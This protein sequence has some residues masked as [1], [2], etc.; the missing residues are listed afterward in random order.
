[1]GFN[2][3]QCGA[4]Y[5]VRKILTN[6]KR[7]KHKDAKQFTCKQCTYETYHILN[8]MLDLCMKKWG[9]FVWCVGRTSQINQINRQLRQ[10][11]TKIVRVN[12]TKRKPSE[13]LETQ[14]KRLKNDVKQG[15]LRCIVCQKE[16]RRKNL[17]KHIKIVHAV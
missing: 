9:R 11:H 10:F 13:S 7:W 14:P 6:H 4:S 5:P 1:M 8:S 3:H 17:N 12:G 15:V 2:C 16:F